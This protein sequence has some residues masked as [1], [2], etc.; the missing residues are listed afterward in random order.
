MEIFSEAATSHPS[1]R[2]AFLDSACDGDAAL[3]AE[4]ES[5]LSVQENVSEFLESPTVDS[6]LGEPPESS[7]ENEFCE[8]RTLQIGC[9]TIVERIGEGGFGVVYRARQSQP[10]RREVALKIVRPGMGIT[11]ASPASSTRGQ[12]TKASP[13]SSWSWCMDRRLL[14]IAI[15]RG[16]QSPSV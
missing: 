15:P 1:H 10:I 9:Y 16:F 3:R 5:L 6:G 11:P 8:D 12:P 13:I 4:V 14:N 7:G 2:A